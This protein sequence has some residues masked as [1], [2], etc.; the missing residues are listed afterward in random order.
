MSFVGLVN[1]V[2]TI[3]SLIIIA[4]SLLSLVRMNPYHPVMDFLIRITEPV[5]APIRQVIPPIGPIDISPLVALLLL[6]FVEW[7]VQALV[8]ALSL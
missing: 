8:M 1:L 6:R 3:Y 7:L 5:L 2:L 4:R